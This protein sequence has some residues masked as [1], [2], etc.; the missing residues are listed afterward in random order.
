MKKRAQTSGDNSHADHSR[1]SGSRWKC[2][3]ARRRGN[4]PLRQRNGGVFWNSPPTSRRSGGEVNAAAFADGFAEV[5]CNGRGYE[6]KPILGDFLRTDTGERGRTTWRCRSE[7]DALFVLY[8]AKELHRMCTIP[9]R[10]YY[11]FI[12]IRVGVLGMGR[13]MRTVVYRT[14][15]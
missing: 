7:C 10:R 11:V 1:S 2:A 14:Y 12:E 15:I 5:T 9:S 6:G 3:G 4:R 13:R 8:S